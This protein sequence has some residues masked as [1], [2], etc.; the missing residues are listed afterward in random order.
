M[1]KREFEFYKELKL[2]TLLKKRNCVVAADRN[3]S[4][5][6]DVVRVGAEKRVV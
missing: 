3:A 6:C 5:L 4:F 2:T 1:K